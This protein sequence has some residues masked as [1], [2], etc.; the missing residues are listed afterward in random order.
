ME[1]SLSSR[2]EDNKAIAANEVL[3]IMNGAAGIQSLA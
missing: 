2:V 1:Y 3:I